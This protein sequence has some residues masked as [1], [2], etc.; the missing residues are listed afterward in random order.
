MS[1]M[2]LLSFFLF[3]GNSLNAQTLASSGIPTDAELFK[4]YGDDFVEKG[5]ASIS[6]KNAIGVLVNSNTSTVQEEA[7]RSVEMYFAHQLLE[8]L[9]QGMDVAKS[10]KV[11]FAKANVRKAGYN[12]DVD[13][14]PIY[15]KYYALLTI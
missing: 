11:A 3:S 9:G 6:T 7:A 1:V 8:A 10:L 13:L 15:T 2:F 4:V 14:D 5:T 12:V